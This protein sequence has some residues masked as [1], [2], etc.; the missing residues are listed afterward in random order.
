MHGP[1][2]RALQQKRS[3]LPSGPLLLNFNVYNRFYLCYG[4]ANQNAQEVFMK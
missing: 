3:V 1:L 4:G 2:L